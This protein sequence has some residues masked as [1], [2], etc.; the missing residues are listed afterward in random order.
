VVSGTV[1]PAVHPVT[2][3]LYKVVR[4]RRRE[5]VSKRLPATGGQFH[6]RLKT[7]GPGRYVVIAQTPA[8]ARYSAASSAPLVVTI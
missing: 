5:T 1:S 6:A 2:V 8:T 4:G 7:R 3:I